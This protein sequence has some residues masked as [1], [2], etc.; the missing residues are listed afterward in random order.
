M[1]SLIFWDITLCKLKLDTTV[2]LCSQSTKLLTV[3]LIWVF[4][5]PHVDYQGTCSSVVVKAL[6]YK[7]EG[8]GFKT[9]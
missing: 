5:P 3:L 2:P 6:S 9:R 1:K 4:P 7:P 8:R